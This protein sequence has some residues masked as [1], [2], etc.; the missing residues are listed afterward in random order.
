MKRKDI[1]AIACISTLVLIL[2]A[3]AVG[4]MPLWLPIVLIR[5][6]ILSDLH[7]EVMHHMMKVMMR[8]M[9]TKGKTGAMK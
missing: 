1:L 2:A 9:I 7:K 5:P 4:L 6:A 8:S 3:L